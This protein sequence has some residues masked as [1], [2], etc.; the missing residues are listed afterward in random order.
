MSTFGGPDD[1]RVGPDEGLALVQPG[2]VGLF[3]GIFLA[4][5]P[6]DTS[7]LARR[8]DPDAY[9]VAC[10]WDYGI[11]SVKYLQGVE[12]T[13]T[14]SATGATATA[15]PVDWGADAGTGRA[16]DLSPGLANHLGLVTGDHCTVDIP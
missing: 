10:R 1:T 5:N 15:R 9:Y 14:N 3:P 13:V 8:L 12:A 7:G 16:A 4:K 6:A 2:D 11:T